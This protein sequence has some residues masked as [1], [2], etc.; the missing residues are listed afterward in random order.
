M[1]PS[2]EF[3]IYFLAFILPSVSDK[4]HK[5]LLKCMLFSE[6][7]LNFVPRKNCSQI[8]I[9][10]IKHIFLNKLYNVLICFLR[11][12]SVSV[13]VLMRLLQSMLEQ[14]VSFTL[15]EPVLASSY[16]A[17]LISSF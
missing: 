17:A 11:P 2:L 7:F 8:I 10:Q 15:G 13:V 4:K 3:L 6:P 16:L 14:N 12:F 5:H 1:L 9:N